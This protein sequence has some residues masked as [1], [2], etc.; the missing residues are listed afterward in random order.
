[1]KAYCAGPDTNGLIVA[2]CLAFNREEAHFF[3]QCKM[4]LLGVSRHGTEGRI[5]SFLT[6]SD[7]CRP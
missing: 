3:L 1:M 5:R 2:I 7:T 4:S 6:H